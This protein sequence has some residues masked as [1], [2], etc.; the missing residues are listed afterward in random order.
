MIAARAQTGGGRGEGRGSDQQ[1]R[2]RPRE[3]AIFCSRSAPKKSRDW[4]IP[5]A[6]EHL[7][8]VRKA[9]NLLGSECHRLDATPR[10]LVLRADGLARAAA[11]YRRGRHRS[12]EVTAGD[13]RRGGFRQEAGRDVERFGIA[14][15]PKGEY[16]ELHQEGR[17]PRRRREFLPKRCPADSR[18]PLPEDHVLDRERTAR[19]S[20]VRSAGS[21]RCSAS[22]SIPFEIAGV[23]SGNV[24]RGHRHSG[25][26]AR[27]R[28]PSRRTKRE[29]RKNFVILSGGRARVRRSR[30]NR[31]GAR[32]EVRRRAARNADVHHR[33][34]RR[35]SSATS[36]RSISSCPRKC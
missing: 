33:V 32:R 27:S 9:R 8:S 30:R 15:T 2:R 7:T 6:L 1:Q 17:R 28:S 21:W 31:A 16:Y 13:R 22:R 12:A 18:D 14:S 5:G 26:D 34:S 11:G 25:R 3:P 19:A 20:S 4:M 36:I 29:L 35:R 10:R 23:K 24:T